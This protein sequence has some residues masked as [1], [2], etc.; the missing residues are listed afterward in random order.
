MGAIVGQHNVSIAPEAPSPDA[1]TETG[2]PL[3]AV[4]SI[5]EKYLTEKKQ[6]EVKAGTNTLDIKYP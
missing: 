6:I 3:V 2:K 1:P 4:S 5:P